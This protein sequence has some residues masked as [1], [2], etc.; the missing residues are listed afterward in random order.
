MDSIASTYDALMQSTSTSTLVLAS[1]VT[2]ILLF[3][4]SI[5][6][7]IHSTIIRQKFGKEAVTAKTSFYDLVDVDMKGSNIPMSTYRNYVLLLVNV[8]SKWGLTKL[9]YTE[10]GL[11]VDEF[12]SKGLKVLLFPCNQFANQ[13]PGTHDEILSFVE[14]KFQSKDKYEWFEKNDVNGSKTR[15]V[16]SYLKSKISNSVTGSSD[17]LW[18]FEKFL[19]TFD[20]EV[21]QRYSPKVSPMAI[22]EDIEKLL[23]QR[24]ESGVTTSK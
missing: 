17:I 11:L 2:L 14:R 13:E 20:G 3:H 4:K 19:V 9:N 22:K 15:E 10:L 1:T 7:I 21:F 23:L 5:L 12:G 24:K 8:A 18:N 6:K 16:F